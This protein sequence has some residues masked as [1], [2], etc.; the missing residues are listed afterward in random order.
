MFSLGYWEGQGYSDCDFQQCLYEAWVITEMATYEQFLKDSL[1]SFI[2]VPYILGWPSS[3]LWHFLKSE[4]GVFRLISSLMG[5]CVSG[6]VS[7]WLPLV[8]PKQQT[9]TCS[10]NS[11]SLIIN[12]LLLRFWRTRERLCMNWLRSLLSMLCMLLE[13]SFELW[14]RTRILLL[15]AALLWTLVY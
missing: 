7:R 15:T 13:Y 5:P 2:F 8:S 11:R 14:L 6:T 9:W 10:T 12:L 3:P 1:T 4:H